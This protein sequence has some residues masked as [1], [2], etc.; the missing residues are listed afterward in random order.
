[1][2]KVESNSEMDFC[3]SCCSVMEQIINSVRCNDLVDPLKRLATERQK[4]KGRHSLYRDILYL[5]FT[6]LGRENIDQSKLFIGDKITSLL[7]Q[8]Q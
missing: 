5:A 8:I 7:I 4:L 3:V 2:K 1:M 6:V